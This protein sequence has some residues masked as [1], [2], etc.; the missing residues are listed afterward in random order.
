M[1]AGARPGTVVSTDLFYDPRED[2]A[3]AWVR[4]GAS[5]VEME[6][7]TILQVAARRGVAAA[8][9]VAVTD[10]P[11]AGGPRR[12]D[13][14]QLEQIGLRVG[15]AGY[16]ALDTGRALRLGDGQ[17]FLRARHRGVRGRHRLAQR[18]DVAR[19]LVE[20][21]LDRGERLAGREPGQPLVQAIDRVLDALQPLRER[22]QAARD[23]F[24]VGCGG[25]VE[26]PIAASW[27]C[28]AFSRASNARAIAPLT[29]GLAIS[30]SAIFPSASS[31]WRDSFSTRVSSCSGAAIGGR[32][33]DRPE[34]GIS[35][36]LLET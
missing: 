8:C 28:T 9:V 20:A 13:V 16:A 27:A 21:G 36:P 15:E 10:V 2:E 17:A 26:R 1:A 34:T 7:A 33:A 11:A 18:R 6:A 29:M 12:A 5:V 25:Q 35:N 4:R 31:P 23:A 24:D 22:P 30:S 3:A 14:E 32:V 19:D